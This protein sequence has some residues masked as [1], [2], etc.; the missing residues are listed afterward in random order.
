MHRLPDPKLALLGVLE[1]FQEIRAGDCIKLVNG[2]LSAV[3][4][5][6]HVHGSEW[7]KA[8]WKAWAKERI[9]CIWNMFVLFQAWLPAS[10][11]TIT[12]QTMAIWLYLFTSTFAQLLFHFAS[13]RAFLD[14]APGL[15][16]ID[17]VDFPISSIIPPARQWQ[18]ESLIFACLWHLMAL[19]KDLVLFA[20]KWVPYKYSWMEWMAFLPNLE[21]VVIPFHPLPEGKT[22]GWGAPFLYSPLAFLVSKPF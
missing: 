18:E 11:S 16:S 5:P 10:I 20:T 12:E 2:M 9:L 4:T 21:V 8:K 14:V 6:V 15:F 19:V 7:R 17:P 1:V 13:L 3:D 22:C